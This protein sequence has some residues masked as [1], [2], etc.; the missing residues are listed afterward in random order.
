MFKIFVMVLNA[1][2]IQPMG[3]FKSIETWP[4]KAACEQ[5]MVAE[6]K[7]LQ[8]KLDA[9]HKNEAIVIVKCE[10]DGEPS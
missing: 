9:E 5:V 3:Y 7:A 8:A 4:T 1:A 6:Q 2:T 10:V